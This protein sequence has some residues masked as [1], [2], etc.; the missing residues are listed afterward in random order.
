MCFSAS[1]S[2][3]SSCVQMCVWTIQPGVRFLE[4]TTSHQQGA[5]ESHAPDFSG[6][7]LENS[8]R[9]ALGTQETED[10]VERSGDLSRPTE[11]CKVVQFLCSV[12][13]FSLT[14]PLGRRLQAAP[15]TM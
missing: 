11:S 2:V 8:W 15:A 10:L 4:E 14:H 5:P 1:V 13:D 9:V 3:S 6:A 7:D 12:C